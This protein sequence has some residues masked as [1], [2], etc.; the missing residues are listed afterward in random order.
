MHVFELLL[1]LLIVALILAGIARRVGAPYPTFLAIGGVLLALTPGAPEVKLDPDLVLA[2]F[3]AP[4]LLD[5]AYDTSPRELKRDWFQLTSLAVGVVVA[6]IAAVAVVARWL[7]PG[8]P[9]SVAVALGA[10]VAPTDAIAATVVLRPLRLPHRLITLIEGEGLFND[11]TALIIYRVAVTT[12]LTG[13]FVPGSLAIGFVTGVIGGLILGV[14]LAKISLAA[15]GTIED[16]SSAIIMQFVVTFLIWILADELGLSA[17]LTLVAYAITLARTAP[18]RNTARRRLPSYAVWEVVV[19]LLNVLAF[20]LIGLQLRPQVTNFSLARNGRDVAFALAIFATTLL[21]R[22]MWVF[23]FMILRRLTGRQSA[24]GL[25]TF[26]A[27]VK[28]A[29]VL[30]WSGMRGV[31]T[32]ATALAL[33]ADGTAF[34]YR[35]L[36]I[37]SA[38]MVVFGS[39]VVQGL[40]LQPLLK[41]LDLR[42]DDPVGIE[43]ARARRNA[44][45]AAI[46]SLDGDRSAAAEAVRSDYRAQIEAN[47]DDDLADSLVDSDQAQLRRRAVHA[48][49]KTIFTMRSSGEIGDDAFHRL[50][51][52]LDVI[53][54]GVVAE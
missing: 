5:A 20:T 15:L 4:V 31:I 19:F 13:A 29:V 28:G 50:E 51:A 49:R 41:M 34:P 22:F 45:Q 35:D 37:L 52:E 42:D 11:A 46:D 14:V 47:A 53:E 30:I 6:T 21:V 43:T 33:P 18:A 3:V 54:I 17:V 38:F 16:L 7:V 39:L 24:F 10:V 1:I 25:P 9:W 36:V 26:G 12:A 27:T 44:W 40:T 48:A 2:L 32:V 23:L 8:M